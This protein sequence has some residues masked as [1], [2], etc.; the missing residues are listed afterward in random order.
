MNTSDTNRRSFLKTVATGTAGAAVTGMMISDASGATPSTTQAAEFRRAFGDLWNRIA[1]Y[2]VDV[3]RAM[4]EEH[5]DYKPT[6]DVRSFKEEMLHIAASDFWIN[7]Y[8]GEG[9]GTGDDYGAEGKSKADC[10]SLM[11]ASFENMSGVIAGLS[12]EQLHTNVET[13]A[14][15]MNRMSV[16]W[17]M[18]DHITHHRAKA[19]VYLRMN[20]VEPPGYVGS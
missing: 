2:T 16:L 6:A 17:F 3:A 4:P 5:Y 10:V 1:S 20:G 19:V 18:R 15:E 8:F 14:G 11:E 12:D 7:N 9:L 13:F